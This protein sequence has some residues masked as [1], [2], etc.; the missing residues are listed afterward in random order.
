[1]KTALHSRPRAIEHGLCA[2]EEGVMRTPHTDGWTRRRFLGG[3][4]VAGAAGLLGWQPRVVAAGAAPGM[5]KIA[6]GEIDLG[7]MSTSP[8]VRRI[9]AGDPLVLLAGIHVGCFELFG[10][11]RVRAIRDLKGKV[12]AVSYLGGTAHL[13]IAIMAAY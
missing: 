10:H 12:V 6:A 3:L 8:A 1:M 5:E 9:E 2:R 4:T 7:L 13:L 11:E